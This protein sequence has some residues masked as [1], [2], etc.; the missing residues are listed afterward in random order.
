MLGAPYAAQAAVPVDQSPLII[1]QPLPPNLVLMLDDSGSMSSDFMPDWSYIPDTSVDGLRYYGNN[2]TYYNPNL[3]YTPPPKADGTDYPNSPGLGNAFRDGF[4]DQSTGNEVDITQYWGSY[5]YYETLTSNV[6]NNYDPVMSCHYG[7][8]LSTD[9]NHQGECQHVESVSY[10]YYKPDR[11]LQC[12]GNDKLVFHHHRWTCREAN[13]TYSYY[14]PDTPSCPLG[15]TFD[16]SQNKCIQVQDVTAKLFTYTT[17]DGSG[18]YVRH[19]VGKTQQDCAVAIAEGA[20]CD[21]SAATQQS[22]ANWFSYYRTRI[23]MA[24]SGLM[25]SFIDIDPTFRIGFG[26]INGRNNANLPANTAVYNSKT[27]AQVQP[28]GDGSSGTQ[29]SAF[30]TW[31]AGVEPNNSTPLRLSLDAVGKYYESAQPWQTSSSDSTELACRQSYTILTTDGFWNGGSPSVGNVDGTGGAQRS[32]PNGQSYTYNAV[33]PYADSYSDTL[34]DV[35]MKYWLTDLRTS[36]SN[37]VPP[38]SDDP[39]FWQHMTTF[40]LGLGFKP[41]HISPAGTTVDQV[42]DW[43]NGGSAISGFSW[44]QPASND[45]NNIADL[46]HAAVNGHGG[47]YS[48]TSPQAFTN[49]LQDALKRAAERV[50]TGASLAANS[51]ELKTGTVAYQANYYTVKWK[52]DLKALTIDPNT[53]AIAASP[54]WQAANVMPS[55]STRN[56][57][58]YNPQGSTPS[59]QYVQFKT[60]SSLSAAQQAALGLNATDQQN[61]INYLRGDSSMEQSQTNGIYRTRDTSLGDIV[62]SQPVYVGAPVANQFYGESFTGS[63]DYPLYATNNENR[64]ALVYLAA[65]DGMLHAFDAATGKETFAYLPGSVITN[66]IASLADPKYGTIAAPHQ[67]FNDGELTVAD[68]Y[69][70]GSWHTV[71]V[72]TTG[73]GTAKTVYALDITSPSNIKLLWERSSG[74]GLTNS[75]YIGQM[76]GKPVI[77]QTLDGSWSVLIG[78]GYNSTNGVAALLQFD[79]ATGDLSVH[80]TSDTS[81][82]NGMSAPAVWIDTPTNGVST[83][84]YAGDLDGHVWSF[85]LQNNSGNK[86]TPDSTG[87][88]LFTAKDASGNIQPIT[89]GLLAGKNPT[90]NDVWLF[91]GT[92]RYLSSSDLTDLSTQTWYGIIAQSATTSLV[93]N[94]S[95]GRSALVQR[96]IIGQTPGDPTASPP[97]LP[98]RVVTPPPSTSDM[99]GKS[100]WYMDL[101]TPIVS[102]ST[103]ATS[104][105]AEGERMVTPNQFQG[106][107]LLGTT[108]IPQAKDLCNPSGSGWIMAVDP[109][110]GTNPVSD[111][112]DVN[113]NGQIN[114]GDS[115]TI[116]GKTYASAGVGFSSLPNNPIFVGGTMLVSFDNGTTGSLQTSGSTG[117]LGR[118]SWREL[119][120]Q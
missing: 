71:L 106:N 116:N 48:A 63:V 15:G 76:T 109:F 90:T 41:E 117:G 50:G 65:N 103:G 39:A 38:S 120:T 29:K 118:V 12:N 5:R 37:E 17:P 64:K 4:T 86:A 119:T 9:P 53:G 102:A 40:T 91:F 88:L 28:F 82:D 112:F 111:F 94:L 87:T 34:A 58:T 57:Y 19:Y 21:Y 26:S 7:D 89:G 52:G 25:N 23:E 113:G 35:A 43:A 11:Y 75:G 49:G 73:R 47:F 81:T 96:Q 2:G 99:T 16:G 30:W 10:R 85:A 45:V 115:V 18:G 59:A 79:L 60:L 32:G 107:V 62:D 6:Q 13:I 55:W 83:T 24:K 98:A 46:A 8:V 92:G 31:L 66:G 105:I 100:G 93:S 44:P 42:F 72:G 77:A 101:L 70:S 74:D 1:Q 36:V 20:D 56:I 97:T 27:I 33:A 95:S 78:N 54:A 51:T 80:L 108:R 3:I 68:V 104:Y 69:M 22:V 14:A 61:I 67:Y 110:T 84:A 114:S